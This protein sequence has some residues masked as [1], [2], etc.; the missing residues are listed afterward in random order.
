MNP[1]I[2]ENLIEDFWLS[3]LVNKQGDDGRGIMSA[4]VQ[5]TEIV[6]SEKSDSGGVSTMLHKKYLITYWRYIEH[7]LMVCISGNKGTFDMLNREQA[8]A[9]VSLAMNWEYNF[10]KFILNEMKGNLKGSKV[11]RFIMY[12]KFLQMIFD[13]RYPILQRGIVTRD[14]KLLNES[15]FLLMLQ[16]RGGKY[17]FQ[18]LHQLRNFGQFVEIE[19]FDAGE[20]VIPNVFVEEEH[21]V[22]AVSSKNSDEDVYVFKLPER[23]NILTKES[24]DMVFDFETEAHEIEKEVPV[25]VSLLTTEN[26]DALLE[27][28]K[29]SVANPP[30]APSFTEQEPPLDV[31][32][33]L[34][35]QLINLETGQRL[36]IVRESEVLNSP[37]SFHSVA[38]QIFEICP[39]RMQPPDLYP[40]VL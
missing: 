30:L 8:S 27:Y 1:V 18:G 22:E 25:Q 35:C 15:T 4:K 14:L 37:I 23:E 13:E 10:S 40:L 29:R 12:P 39:L 2:H 11:K 17:Q 7:V 3:A 34:T 19:G 6:I 32:A 33:D 28:V 20:N 16:N 31:N 5:N 21:D 26:L 38:P 24:N 36:E 9:F